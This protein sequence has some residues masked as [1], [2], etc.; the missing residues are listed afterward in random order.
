VG[1][2]FTI[3]PERLGELE[4]KLA[5]EYESTMRRA[6]LSAAMRGVGL[7]QQRTRTAL[8]ASPGGPSAGGAVN[9]GTY[10][11]AWKAEA[12]ADGASLF[13]SSKQAGVIEFGRR[14][15]KFPPIAAIAQWALRRLRLKPE[16]SRRGRSKTSFSADEIM[17]PAFR[18]AW[19][20]ARAI[21]RRGLLPRLIMTGAA[22]VLG[23]YFDEE[24]DRATEAALHK[25]A[26]R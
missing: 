3:G 12:D 1:T 17:T 24:I 23:A 26:G 22:H 21:A 19:P 16:G 6:A 10:L 4:T 13:N 7:M 25:A 9:Y 5:G 14:P 20:I 11:R 18:A 8:P 15:G 2:T